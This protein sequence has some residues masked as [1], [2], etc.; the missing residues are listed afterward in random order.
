MNT[1]KK[2]RSQEDKYFNLF[3]R[4]ITQFLKILLILSCLFIL[5]LIRKN[6][7]NSLNVGKIIAYIIFASVLFVIL[8]VT[9][10]Y[11]YNQLLIGL[12]VYFGFEMLRFN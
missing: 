7:A 12:G 4:I 2:T 5:I 1:C 3:Y 8:N 10:S 11:F 6:I 9:D